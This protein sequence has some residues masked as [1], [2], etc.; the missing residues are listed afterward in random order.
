MLRLITDKSSRRHP[1]QLCSRKQNIASVLF[2]P[3]R[4][5]DIHHSF[6][7][8][9]KVKILGNIK[10]NT[11]LEILVR[12]GKSQTANILSCRWTPAL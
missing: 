7:E 6:V 3:Y 10:S 5:T 1:Q 9:V 8:D 11:L 2:V 4:G 12:S